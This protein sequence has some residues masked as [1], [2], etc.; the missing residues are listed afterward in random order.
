M[1]RLEPEDLSLILETKLQK[2]QLSEELEMALEQELGLIE[3]DP[4]LSSKFDINDY[5]N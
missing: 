5:I 1:E 3:G 4:L 2:L